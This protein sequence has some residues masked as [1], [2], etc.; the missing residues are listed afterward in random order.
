MGNIATIKEKAKAEFE[1]VRDVKKEYLTVEQVTLIHTSKIVSHHYGV[2]LTHLGIL[3]VLDRYHTGLIDLEDFMSFIEL[4][5]KREKRYKEPHEFQTQFQAYCTLVMWNKVTGKDGDKLF[6]NWI[7]KLFCNGFKVVQFDGIE[8]VDRDA[9]KVLHEILNISKT[10][11]VD[12]Q[13]FFD[14]M[15]RSAE[16]QELMPLDAEKVDD[17]VPTLLL[18]Q[19]ASSFLKGFINLMSELGFEPGINIK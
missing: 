8:F 7:T 4:C 6:E 9:I 1:R 10:H 14:L 2:D 16:K 12:F 11:G 13:E 5:H 19:F 3:F 15:Q 18:R 17:F